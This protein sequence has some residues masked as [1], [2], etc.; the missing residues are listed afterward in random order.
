MGT[1]LFNAFA[2]LQQKLKKQNREYA[3]VTV[4]IPDD[5]TIIHL[6]QDL[7]IEREE[8]EAAFINGTVQPFDS[9]LQDGDRI[10]LVPPGTPGPYRVFL[11][12]KNKGHQ[13]IS[14]M[15]PK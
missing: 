11:G 1:I 12:M 3:N 15:Q 7:G 9:V 10:A 4:E 5:Y 13:A 14:N 8:V 6:M 2:A